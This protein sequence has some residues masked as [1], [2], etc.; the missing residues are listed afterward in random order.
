MSFLRE[1]Q[2]IYNEDGYRG[3][4]MYTPHR[5]I[6]A[7]VPKQDKN[8]LSFPLPTTSPDKPAYV[9]APMG[10]SA[11][12]YEEGDLGEIRKDSIIRMIER[13]MQDAMSKEM[14][15]CVFVLGKLKEAIKEHKD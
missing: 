3:Q 10:V 8:S 6:G 14:T 2:K 12:E 5:V 13:E 15:Y 4:S 1:I 7:Q 11:I 9:P